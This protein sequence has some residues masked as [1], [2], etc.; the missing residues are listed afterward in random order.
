MKAEDMIGK[1]LVDDSQSYPIF[2]LIKEKLHE[3]EE[4][5]WTVYGG[6]KIRAWSPPSINLGGS[7]STAEIQKMYPA[8]PAELSDLAKRLAAHGIHIDGLGVEG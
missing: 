3:E 4:G 7:W 1:C 8:T 2:A 6:I 5:G